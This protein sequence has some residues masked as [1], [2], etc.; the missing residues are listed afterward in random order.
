M[1]SV[2]IKH[3]DSE[4]NVPL[5]S[6]K[7]VHSD[8]LAHGYRQRKYAKKAQVKEL[9]EKNYAENG[10][11][12]TFEDIMAR[13][14]VSKSKAQRKLKHFLG[15]GFVFTAEDLIKEGIHLNGI[16]RKNPQRYYLTDL[17]TKIIESRNNNVQKDTTVDMVSPIAL[18]KAHNFR[19]LL[20]QLALYLLYIHKLQI[21]TSIPKENY[22]LIDWSCRKGAA[23]AI[24]ERIGIHTV[25]FHIHPNG[26][27]MIYV[28]CSDKPFRLH[29]EQDVSD[30]L[31]FLG[32][33]SDRFAL[34]LH[35]A[36]DNVVPPLRK[37]ILKACDVS[38]DVEIDHVAQITLPGMQVP[39]FE[40]ALRGY[41]KPIGDKV[42]YRV[43]LALTPNKPVEEALERLRTEVVIDKDVFK[44]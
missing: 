37:W 42:F 26:S 29:E 10:R 11:G 23:K 40:K 13:F 19:E 43:E 39:L 9:A 22:E 35:D 1:T 6:K 21:W 2:N 15:E 8:E 38:K 7:S 5:P 34:L 32:R 44:L 17:K 31:F 12:I 33:V 3:R 27:V 20:T 30:I 36:R 24:T 25:E 14:G 16:K 18:Q 4:K 41:V 28:S